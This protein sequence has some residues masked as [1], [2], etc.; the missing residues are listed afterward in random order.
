MAP[1]DRG[2]ILRQATMDGSL[3]IELLLALTTAESE[4]RNLPVAYRKCRYK[5][6]N[7]LKYFNVI[8]KNFTN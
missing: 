2:T 5:D 4:V 6:E 7:H 3:T 1:F 8:K